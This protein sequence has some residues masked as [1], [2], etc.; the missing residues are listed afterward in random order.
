[1]YQ[2][3]QSRDQFEVH[4]L[5]LFDRRIMNVV[6]AS[7]RKIAKAKLIRIDRKAW[8]IPQMAGRRKRN[9]QILGRDGSLNPTEQNQHAQPDEATT[10]QKSSTQRAPTSNR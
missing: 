1:M 10:T 5:L 3:G 8:L 4:K 2:A 6:I 9:R 7:A